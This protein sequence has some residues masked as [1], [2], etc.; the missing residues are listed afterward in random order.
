MYLIPESEFFSFGIKAIWDKI[1]KD[2]I[3]FDIGQQYDYCSLWW[4][5]YK[6]VIIKK[7]LLL[8]IDS[9]DNPSSLW[10]LMKRR[11]YM[12]NG[13]HSIG[14]IDGLITDY[15]LPIVAEPLQFIKKLNEVVT[16]INSNKIEWNYL[17]INIPEWS[18]YLNHDRINEDLLEQNRL[19]WI[20]KEFDKYTYINLDCTF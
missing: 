8:L 3:V 7:E 13:I 17:K 5:T 4:I 15:A 16:F 9:L 12:L 6:N 10:P 1:V 19:K 18:G 2:G 14:Q 11:Q 20:T